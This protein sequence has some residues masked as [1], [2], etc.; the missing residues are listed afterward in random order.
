[1]IN[2]YLPFPRE[3]PIIVI[4][5]ESSFYYPFMI[6]PIFFKKKE[7]IDAIT[8][9]L[10]SDSIIFLAY[11]KD[12]NLNSIEDS[13]IERFGVIGSI[14][15]KVDMPDGRVKILFQGLEKGEIIDSVRNSKTRKI[16]F[17]M[18]NIDISPKE[19]YDKQRSEAI[20]SVLN[21]KLSFYAKL[22]SSIPQD[23]L[24]TIYETN[25]PY[26]K[27]ELVASV[28]KFNRTVAYKFYKN[29]N[30]EDKLLDIIEYIISEINTLKIQHEIRK[31]VQVK[32]D[33]A[34]KEYFLREQLREIHKELGDD[35]Q[36]EDDV[37]KMRQRL[38][39]ITPFI[40]E[41][42]L[43]EITKQINRFAKITGENS[44][45]AMLQSYLESV[46]EIPF[47][48]E[49]SKK[50]SIKNIQKELDK[51]HFS[52]EVAKDK[53]VEFFATKELA[54]KRAVENQKDSGMILCFFGPPGVGK[55]SLANSI[56]NALD[57]PLVRIALGGLEDV[58]ELRGHRRTY[59]GAMVGRIV[60]GLIEAK[61]MNPVVVLDEIDKIGRSYKGDPTA[62]LLEIL[63]PEQ[64]KAYRD[65]YLNFSI[66]LSKVIFVAT[67]N[68]Y[69]S[70]P[71]PL[72]DRMERI[73]IGSYMPSEKFEIAKKYL[74]PQEL[75][76]H[77]LSRSEFEINADA[78]K[79][80]I[81]EYTR[82]AGVRNLRRQIASL[83]RKSAKMILLDD[84]LTKVKIT[85]KNI[86]EFFKEKSF[87][88]TKIED[89]PRIG[90]VNGM[91]WTS[92]GGEILKIEIIKTKGNGA[93]KIT[94]S[95]GDV[96]KESVQIAYSAVKIL[97]DN[98]ELEIDTSKI[99]LSEK[100]REKLSEGKKVEL[101]ASDVYKRY[102]LHIHFPEGAIKKDGPSAGIAI[103]SV[104]ASTLSDTSIDNQVAMTGEINLR[105]GVLPI[106]GLKEKLIGAF[107]AGV[108]KVI[109]P[110]KNFEHDLHDISDEV[111]D[112]LEIIG[113]K[114][115]KE[116]LEHILLRDV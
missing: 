21:E 72:R 63:D 7:D 66:D 102:D 70:I 59:I 57:R 23:L 76:K 2:N 79:M 8:H 12:V 69:G 105:G 16:K 101:D 44:D 38:I 97:I 5:D 36:K 15:R 89:S 109:I 54:K 26:R 40:T 71:A 48:K 92:V 68:D 53:I 112:S 42:A 87:Q 82:E 46:F 39:E 106:G 91:V 58:N 13:N 25:E 99:P 52:L 1:M 9:S 19:P 28:L 114:D 115:V 107:K 43:K 110:A 78:L 65:Y 45:S 31:K 93:I 29:N 83:M 49:S 33:H 11:S 67:A 98:H 50:L 61:S 55:T 41:D 17:I 32:I 75:K 10:K 4:E 111:K 73:Y 20:N 35:T 88:Y 104:I 47:D 56:A 108:K 24:T 86:E 113:V 37:L 27:A 90:V 14:M 116:V 18:A 94:G 51:D 100:E 60:Q 81:D 103:A 74:I 84:T 85:P 22:N 3:L 64:N 34:N 62:A 6:S 77:S 95:L 80:L 96:M 30:I